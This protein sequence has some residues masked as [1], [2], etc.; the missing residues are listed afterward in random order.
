MLTGSKRKIELIEKGKGHTESDLIMFLPEEGILFAGDLVF[1]EAH[2]YLGYGYTVELKE[3]L[4]ELELMK[5]E[6]VVPGHGD[7][8][9]VDIITSIREYIEDLERIVKD[10]KD[11]GG[12]AKDIE[13]FPMPEKYEGWIMGN[14]FYSNLKYLFNK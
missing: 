14:F 7:P 10:L 1:N 2:P 5:P 9:G 13:N 11:A 6:I 4:K 3:R 12:T 8:G